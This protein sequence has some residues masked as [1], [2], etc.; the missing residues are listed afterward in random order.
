MKKR[1]KTPKT[2]EL[3]QSW[4]ALCARWGAHQGRRVT[5]RV[6]RVPLHTPNPLM[7]LN[8]DRLAS[9]IPTRPEPVFESVVSMDYAVSERD[10]SAL[11]AEEY[12]RR[13]T[14]ARSMKHTIMPGHKQG[15]EVVTDLA[16]VPLMGK[17]V[18]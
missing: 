16:L 13:E 9:R 5:N 15:Y 11:A 14:A 8:R 7:E 4:E 1:R 12:D 6:S 17:K 18:V 10:V 2:Q 3:K